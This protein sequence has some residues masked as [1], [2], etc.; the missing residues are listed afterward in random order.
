MFVLSRINQKWLKVSLFH[1]LLSQYTVV[2]KALRS[3]KIHQSQERDSAM[4]DSFFMFNETTIAEWTLENF[5]TIPCNC[6]YATTRC[7][8]MICLNTLKS[9]KQTLESRRIVTS[10]ET[11]SNG[12]MA[13]K[14]AP[15]TFLEAYIENKSALQSDYI[16]VV[17]SSK[18]CFMI[19][20]IFLP[21]I[22][23]PSPVLSGCWL[24][25]DATSSE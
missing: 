3:D 17:L 16:L 18:S 15:K 5:L 25:T 24:W 1:P 13:T 19:F 2:L 4:S 22:P 20:I 12:D 14:I 23:S 6:I 7:G 9:D 10:C 21:F 11:G 8:W